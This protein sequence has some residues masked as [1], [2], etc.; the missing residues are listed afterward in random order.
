MNQHEALVNAANINFTYRR[1]P[2]NTIA[3]ELHQALYDLL[4]VMINK[5]PAQWQDEDLDLIEL[6]AKAICAVFG[7]G[8]NMNRDEPLWWD[9]DI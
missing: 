9:L 4:E 1:A 3:L 2:D 7:V 5:P 6:Q 8:M